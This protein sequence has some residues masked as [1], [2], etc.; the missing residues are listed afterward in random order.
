ME[1]VTQKKPFDKLAIFSFV[2]FLF[3]LL[4]VFFLPSGMYG[5][6]ISVFSGLVGVIALIKIL[7][8]KG[9][10]VFLTIFPIIWGLF[11]GVL[12]PLVLSSITF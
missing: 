8:Q 9:R 6:F 7:K 3:S 11:M 4:C 5:V 12:I 1:I 2:L 10:G